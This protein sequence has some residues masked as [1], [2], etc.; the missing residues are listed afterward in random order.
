MTDEQIGREWCERNGKRPDEYP[1]RGLP[2]FRWVCDDGPVYGLPHVVTREMGV[3]RYETES[4]AYAAVGAA[5]RALRQRAAE[6]AE[7]L[8][9]VPS[10]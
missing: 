6:I 5:L 7:V 9:E 1:R 8:V 4:D 3:T 2:P 10:D